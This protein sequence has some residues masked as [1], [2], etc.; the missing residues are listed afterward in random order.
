MSFT[1]G[2]PIQFVFQFGDPIW[3]PFASMT[4]APIDFFVVE[5]PERSSDGSLMRF[6]RWVKGCIRPF[7]NYVEQSKVTHNQIWWATKS[8]VF[9]DKHGKIHL[10]VRLDLFL[11]HAIVQS[12]QRVWLDWSRS[13][14]ES[15]VKEHQSG[16]SNAPMCLC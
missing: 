12:L 10:Q 2:Y 7:T 9:R 5:N 8:N 14:H 3:A 15:W 13:L 16:F 11:L 4:L 6:D 1:L